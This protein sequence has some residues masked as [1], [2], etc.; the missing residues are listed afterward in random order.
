MLLPDSHTLVNHQQHQDRLREIEH[1]R[2]L[3]LIEQQSIAS[4]VYQRIVSWLGIQLVNWGTK[5]QEYAVAT[6]YASVTQ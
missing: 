1:L 2:L 5:L 6:H 4:K 3:H